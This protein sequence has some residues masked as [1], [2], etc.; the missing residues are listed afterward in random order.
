MTSRGRNRSFGFPISLAGALF[1]LLLAAVA[2]TPFAT[3]SAEQRDLPTAGQSTLSQAGAPAVQLSKTVVNPAGDTITVTGTGFLPSLSIGTRPPLA[4]Q[5]AGAYIAFG[6]FADVWKPSAGAP[7]SARP[8]MTSVDGGLLWAVPQASRAIV[9]EA[10]SVTL[11]PDGSFTATLKVK[12]DFAGALPT[13]NY[14]IYTYPGSGAVQPL[15]E[16]F[17]PVTFTAITPIATSSA[18]PSATASTTAV[19][20]ASP[21]ASATT[22]ATAPATATAAP[23]PPTVGTGAPGGTSFPVSAGLFVAGSVLLAVAGAMA[24]SRRKI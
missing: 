4:G 8:T 13:G 2:G 1:V 7:S 14:G 19:P 23:K 6:A 20:S 10:D 11:N 17:T 9:G 3:A 15:F 16:T 18:S 12:K 22:V 24:I 21:S 5:P